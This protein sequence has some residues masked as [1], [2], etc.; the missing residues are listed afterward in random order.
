VDDTLS[1][2]EFCRAMAGAALVMSHRH[3]ARATNYHLTHGQRCVARDTA[4]EAYR[5]HLRWIQLAQE[6]RWRPTS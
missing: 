2:P 6:A 3:K 4:A 1:N 5:R